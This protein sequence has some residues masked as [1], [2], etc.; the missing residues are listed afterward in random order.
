MSRRTKLEIQT[1]HLGT[2]TCA[3][4]VA[5]EKYMQN[6]AEA[7]AANYPALAEQFLRQHDDA[8]KLAEHIENNA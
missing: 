7:E 4:R 5:A 2:I 3:L 6:A 1:I 8:I